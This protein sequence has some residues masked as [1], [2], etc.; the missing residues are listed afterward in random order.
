[1]D[2]SRASTLVLSFFNSFIW[3]PVYAAVSFV[4]GNGWFILLL[5]VFSTRYARLVSAEAQSRARA[6][7]RVE[8]TDPSRVTALDERRVDALRALE[9][10]NEAA[11]EAMKVQVLKEARQR[12]EEERQA[13]AKG[14][15]RLGDNSV[16]L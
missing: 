6:R 7:S 4:A 12:R 13:Q 15:H 2:R 3:P 14:G 8:A 9:S 5:A 16:G 1:M 11:I 10:R